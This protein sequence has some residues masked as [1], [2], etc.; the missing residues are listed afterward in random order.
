MSNVVCVKCQHNN[1]LSDATYCQNCGIE[2]LNFCTN[3]DCPSY[4]DEISYLPK[5]ASFCPYC[6]EKTTYYEYLNPLSE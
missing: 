4:S 1:H 3:D 2:L 5:D 6:G